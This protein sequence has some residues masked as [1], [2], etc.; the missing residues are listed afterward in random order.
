MEPTC[1]VIPLRP[2]MVP[3][4]EAWLEEL[5]AN[6]AVE[7]AAGERRLGISRQAWFIAGE[8]RDLL[9]GLVEGRDVTRSMRL[10]AISMEP[11][12]LWFKSSLLALTGIELNDPPA[13]DTANLLGR[14]V[15]HG[16]RAP[17]V[18]LA[19]QLA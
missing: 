3:A 19:S 8:R 12:D 14:Y 9:I 11:F 18:A 16:A 1:L 6:R 2:G 4:A 7:R 17:G 5:A 13:T 15:A 10:L